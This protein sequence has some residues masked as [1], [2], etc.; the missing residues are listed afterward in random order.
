MKV[1]VMPK[2]Y[3]RCVG[4]YAEVK[5]FNKGKESEFA[6]RKYFTVG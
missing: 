4:Y 1:K 2:V 6:N 5:H 3:T